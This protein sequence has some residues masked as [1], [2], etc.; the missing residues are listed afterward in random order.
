MSV[1][2]A[3]E[4]QMMKQVER[5]LK[6]I[7]LKGLSLG[8]FRIVYHVN[9]GYEIDGLLKVRSKEQLLFKKM[10]SHDQ[11]LNLMMVD[12]LFPLMMAEMATVVLIKGPMTFRQFVQSGNLSHGEFL[13]EHKLLQFIHHLLYADVADEKPFNGM[14]NHER[15]YCRKGENGDVEYYSIYDRRELESLIYA[16]A[17][18]KIDLKS[19]VMRDGEATLN[20]KIGLV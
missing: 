6:F 13:M 16:T 15:V 2:T 19:S 5:P 14:L 1:A 10:E 11:Q 8:S 17:N 7:Y 3:R 9:D 4:F 12:S 18:M 20:V